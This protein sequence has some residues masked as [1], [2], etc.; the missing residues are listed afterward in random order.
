MAWLKITKLCP[1]LSYFYGYF[2]GYFESMIFSE[3]EDTKLTPKQS[4][5]IFLV[6]FLKVKQL[7][8]IFQKSEAILSK[9]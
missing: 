6:N 5:R 9:R 8:A 4:E 7:S 2:Y 3:N 1:C